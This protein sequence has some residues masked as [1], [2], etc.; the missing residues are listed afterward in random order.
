M[1]NNPRSNMVATQRS[2]RSLPRVCADREG[3]PL[4]SSHSCVYPEAI[5]SACA[6]QWVTGTRRECQHMQMDQLEVSFGTDLI[7]DGKV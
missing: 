6:L 5:F 4:S 1:V 7:L 3:D 2:Q